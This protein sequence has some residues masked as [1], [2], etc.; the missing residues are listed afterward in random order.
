[1]WTAIAFT[2]LEIAVAVLAALGASF[3]RGLA[4]FGMA[5]LLVPILAL[6]IS[7]V[8][9]VLLANFL[10]L[11]IGM[12]ELPRL[13]REAERSAWVLS[14]FIMVTAPLGVIALLNTPPEI[15]RVVIALIALSAFAAM[16]LPRRSAAEP[17]IAV[18]GGVGALSGL[19]TGYA[20]MP[21]VPVV[22][23]YVG[24]DIARGTA[25][26]SM[27]LLFTLASVPALLAGWA[28]G[29]MDWTLALFAALLLPVILLGNWLGAKASDRIADNTWRTAVGVILAGA[30]V[31]ALLRLT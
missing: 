17:G 10:A 14:G 5:I 29:A 24:R 25:K 27:L 2:P 12:V 23:Y 13:V 30:A 1:M 21:G 4:G 8:D 7:P 22:P 18:S 9:S 31:A 6:A 16:L 28:T 20:G 11:Y 15:A 3:V 26:A 19:L